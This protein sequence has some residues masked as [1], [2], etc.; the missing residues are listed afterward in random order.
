MRIGI[1][2]KLLILV[3][4]ATV[5]PVLLAV[6]ALWTVGY[7][8]RVQ[9]R[10]EAHQAEAAHVARNLSLLADKQIAALQELLDLTPLAAQVAG[11]GPA[12]GELPPA[13]LARQT[14]ELEGRWAGLPPDG[15]ELQPILTNSMA[16]LLNEFRRIHPLF[17][18]ILVTDQYGRLVAATGKTSDYDQSDEEWWRQAM[19]LPGAQAW[20]EG[21]HRDESAGVLSLDVALPVR[22]DTGRAAAPTGAVKAVLNTTPLFGAVRFLLPGE[23][24]WH[25]IIRP[26]GQILLRLQD[27]DRPGQ[28]D[29]IDPALAGLLQGDRPGWKVVSWHGGESR[30]VGYAPL[31]LTGVF[32]EDGHVETRTPFSV[33]V[34]QSADAVLAPL[35]VQTALLTGAGAG[36]TVALVLLG[37][38]LG[39]RNFIRPLEVLRQA[40]HAV[41]ATADAAGPPAS[42][43]S[44]VE[45]AARSALDRTSRLRTGDEIESLAK[46]FNLMAGRLLR[47]QAQLEQEITAKT[48]EIQK[49]LAMAR[50]FQEALLPR[51]YPR[52]PSEREND[53]VY[54]QFHHVYQPTVSLSGD[55]FDV[56]KLGDH[57]AGILIADVMG[58]GTRSAL[59]TAILRTLLQDLA[60]LEG[61]PGQFLS[62]LNR[63]FHEVIQQTDQLVFVSALYVVVDTQQ[64]TLACASAGHPSPLIASHRNGRVEPLFERL[65][66]NPALG[67]FPDS[68]HTVFTR[69]L[70]PDDL[71][72]LFTDGIVEATDGEGEEFGRARLIEAVRS[73][74]R[75]PRDDLCTSILEAVKRHAGQMTL[76]DDVCLVAVEVLPNRG[77]AATQAAAATAGAARGGN[78]SR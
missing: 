11:A 63:H 15:P 6:A 67:L 44:G 26:D 51:R 10:G 21:L 14:R 23:D 74:L 72:V 75:S 37:L 16:V 55:F 57:R 66:G 77:G 70:Q 32:R 65:S 20:V 29:A 31:A 12:E 30:M 48:A 59:V 45:A 73:A 19:R 71:I 1:R 4:V 76:P 13:E 53:P 39:R 78:R 46:D 47:Y 17:A 64:Q 33:I 22:G 25:E 62:R 69:Q 50:E 24:I 18:E 54:L 7:R 8:Y 3:V 42:T 35:R 27:E 5:A 56:I 2:S 28:P 40:A 43:A 36:L 9:G 52:V 68:H 38:Y 58:H 61:D 34:H 41:A 60:R 49:D